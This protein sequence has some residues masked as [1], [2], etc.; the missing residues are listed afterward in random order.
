MATDV[1]FKGV[2]PILVTPFDEKETV[3]LESS[4]RMVEFM[5]EIGVDITKP[6]AL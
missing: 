2:F 4:V 1:T 3:D 5:A 6:L